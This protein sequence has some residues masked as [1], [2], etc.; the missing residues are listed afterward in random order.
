LSF[1]LVFTALNFTTF[2]ATGPL[3]VDHIPDNLSYNINKLVPFGANLVGQVLSCPSTSGLE[4]TTPDGADVINQASIATHIRWVLNDAVVPL[5][6]I[7]G[8]PENSDGLCK[9]ETFISSI[10]ER[11][12]TIDFQFDCFA[13]YTV[14]DPDEIVDGR[15]PK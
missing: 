6:G 7:K 14:P 5:T 13:N 4:A 10:K 2:A 8:C 11:I 9:L 15:F 1:S 3:P 12:E